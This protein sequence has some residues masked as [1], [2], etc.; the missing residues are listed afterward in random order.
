MAEPSSPTAA[1]PRLQRQVWRWPGLLVAC[2]LGLTQLL[3]RSDLPQIY[4]FA[5]RGPPPP[6]NSRCSGRPPWCSPTIR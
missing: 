3:L 1:P 6:A 4:A 2:L 5:V